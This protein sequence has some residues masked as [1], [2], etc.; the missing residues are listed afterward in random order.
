MPDIG[1]VNG[2]MEQIENCRTEETIMPMSCKCILDRMVF[3]GAMT[4]KERDKILRNLNGH[5][6]GK[7]MSEYGNDEVPLD[8]EGRTT[9]SCNCSVCGDWLTASDEYPTRGRYCPN[10]GVKMKTGKEAEE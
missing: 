9:R 2:L 4:E 3:K 6:M 5:K 8:E 10:C 1:Y 7:W